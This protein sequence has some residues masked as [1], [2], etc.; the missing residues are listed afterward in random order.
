M[1]IKLHYKYIY[2]IR[3]D[4]LI[5][6]VI[7]HFIIISNCIASYMSDVAERWQLILLYVL[8]HF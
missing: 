4:E 6:D 7:L 1:M 2:F 8:K 3:E 5:H